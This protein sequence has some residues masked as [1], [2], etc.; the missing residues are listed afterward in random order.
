MRN[1]CVIENISLNRIYLKEIIQLKDKAFQSILVM[2]LKKIYLLNFKIH[3][4][5]KPNSLSYLNKK[6]FNI[7]KTFS[8]T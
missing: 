5:K 1:F 2:K 4:N 7:N 3:K 6:I 8:I